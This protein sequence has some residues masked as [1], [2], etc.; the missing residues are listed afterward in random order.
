MSVWLNADIELLWNRVR[1]RDTRPLLRTAD[2]KATLTRLYEARVPE[3]AK[4]DLEV[5]C[6]PPVAIDL[7]ALRVAEVLL[8]RP[9]VLEKRHA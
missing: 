7:M 1:H 2:P 5:P 9:D 4:A 8:S 3:Y 6:A